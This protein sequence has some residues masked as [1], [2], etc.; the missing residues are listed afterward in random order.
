MKMI[1][2]FVML[3]LM[4]LSKCTPPEDLQA[5]NQFQEDFLKSVNALRV[6]GC[7]CGSSSMPPVAPITWNDQ[8]AEAAQRHAND[9]AKNDHFDH[10]GTD[11][12]SSAQRIS[13][14]GYKWRSVGENIAW[15]YQDIKAVVAGWVKSKGHCQNMMSADYTEMGAAQNGTYWVQTFGKPR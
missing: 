10:T 7:K 4:L 1:H 15:G 2:F 12:S 8:L 13:D 9:M 6:Q 3:Q 14:A 5:D 11:G